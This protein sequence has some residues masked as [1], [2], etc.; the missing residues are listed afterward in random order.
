M[1]ALIHSRMAASMASLLLFMQLPRFFASSIQVKSKICGTDHIVYSTSNGH[2]LFYLNGDLVD[3][4]LFCKTLQLHYADECAFEGF[5]ATNYCDSN[6]SSGNDLYLLYSPKTSSLSFHQWIMFLF[7]GRRIL[8]ET[9]KG[10]DRVGTHRDNRKRKPNKQF[11]KYSD[12]T[13]IGIGAAVG[14]LLICCVYLCC[15]VCRRKR[16]T[17]HTDLT[18]DPNSS[19]P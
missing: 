18:K 4:V 15:G 2:E 5:T 1:S 13:I 19:E 9:E 17:A 7:V 14:T 8:K 6:L 11:R 10:D 12:G 3:K 16:A